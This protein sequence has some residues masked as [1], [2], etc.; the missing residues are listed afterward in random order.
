MS[1]EFGPREWPILIP[2][3]NDQIESV[4]RSVL[5]YTLDKDL[6]GDLGKAIRLPSDDV[7]HIGEAYQYNWQE[8]DGSYE[9]LGCWTSRFWTSACLGALQD[10]SLKIEDMLKLAGAS[11]NEASP[12]NIG[13]LAR[14][15]IG[16]GSMLAEPFPTYVPFVLSLT[17]D[18]LIALTVWWTIAAARMGIVGWLSDSHLKAD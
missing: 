7:L 3:H 11:D 13:F 12:D 15:W 10:N 18:D 8:V 14:D 6:E 2:P 16:T 5:S 1:F 9:M 17:S 4:A